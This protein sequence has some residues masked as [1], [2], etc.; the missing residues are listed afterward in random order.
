[1]YTLL[2]KKAFIALAFVLMTSSAARTQVKTSGTDFWFGFLYG[3]FPDDF[4]IMVASEKGSH[5]KLSMPG[6]GLFDEFVIPPDS[7]IILEYSFGSAYVEIIDS[8]HISQNSVHITSDNPVTV[9]AIKSRMY[10]SDGTLVFPVNA[11]G[12]DYMIKTAT[13]PTFIVLATKDQTV[14]EI[15]PAAP[16]IMGNAVGVPISITLN[17][18]EYYQVISNWGTLTGSTIRVQNPGD[19]HRIAVFEGDICSFI[20]NDTLACNHLFEQSLPVETWGKEFITIP[21]LGRDNYLLTITAKENNTQVSLNNGQAILLN[22]GESLDTIQSVVVN[23]IITSQPVKV[24]QYST[25]SLYDNMTGDPSAVHIPPLSSMENHVPFSPLFT[26]M[27]VN[28][29]I[30]LVTQTANI[31]DI[32]IDGIPVPATDFITI[33]QD[34]AYSYLQKSISPGNHT[35]K[36][37]QGGFSAYA[38]GF[39]LYDAYAMQL[40]GFY[41]IT[42]LPQVIF[43]GDTIPASLF[44]DTLTCHDTLWYYLPD[45]SP[46]SQ[47]EWSVNGDP[48]TSD[49]PVMIT[50]IKAGTNTVDLVYTWLDDP[51]GPDTSS[52]STYTF[53]SAMT[54]VEK[55][56]IP[57]IFTPNHDGT[58]DEWFIQVEPLM[59]PDGRI[60]VYNRWG[61]LVWQGEDLFSAWDGM[62]NGVPAD[63]GTYYYVI[64]PGFVCIESA[65]LKGFITLTR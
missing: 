55:V 12:K 30:N 53:F 57:N 62:S 21:F 9:Y 47:V 37:Q 29:Y 33:P 17:Q 2:K 51:C 10:D 5:C 64:D 6:T 43:K 49:N 1:M 11:L 8:Q 40:G 20:P 46:F 54:Q 60:F 4:R 24:I 48:Y 45:I 56:H 25:G 63:E 42:T 22:A 7:S 15:I 36:S 26:E 18:G 13:S 19:C 39:G 23:H 38:Y 41:G 58:N 44:T 32:E 16:T 65:V 35:L 34:P 27:I 50:G 61:M 28:S 52:G 14:V 31:N 3:F 59:A